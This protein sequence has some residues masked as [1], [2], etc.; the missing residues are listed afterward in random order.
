[1]LHFVQKISSITVFCTLWITTL[2]TQDIIR[3]TGNTLSNVDYHHGQ[4]S[5]VKGVHNI[6]VLRAN[7]EHPEEAEGYGW[8]YSHA[9]M[10]AYRNNTF[11]LQYLSNSVGEHI[12]PGQ[13]LLVTSKDGCRWSKP[14]ALFPRYKIPDGTIKEGYPGV[15]RDLY[16]VMHQRM[17][18]YM[19]EKNRLLAL[20]FYGICMDRKDK[21]NDGK[22]IGRVV[23]EIYPDG[24]FGPVYFIRYNSG[25]G[26]NNTNYSF[27]DTSKDKGFVEAC[28]E[29]LANPLMMQQWN[30]EADRDDPLIPLKKQFKALSYYHLPDGRVVGLWKHALTAISNDEGKTWPRPVRAP[31][32]VNR[33]AKIWGQRTSDG[34]YATVYNP[35]EFR[36]PLAVSVSENGLDYNNLLLVQGEISPMRY[37]GNYKNYGPQYVRG[38]LEGNG[39]PPDG[40][41]WVTYSMNKEDIWVASIPVPVEDYEGEPVNDI[42]SELPEGAELKKWNIYSPIWAPVQIER[43]RDGTRCLSL[44]DRDRYDYAKAERLF[45]VSK[46]LIAEFSVIPA[47]KDK[48]A[49]HIEFQDAKGTAAVRLIFDSDS[50]FKTKYS[51]RYSSMMNYEAGKQYN[52]RVEL[53]VKNRSYNLKV[54]GK[55]EATDRIFFAPVASLERIVFRTGEIRRFPNS[56]TPAQQDFDLPRA[57]EPVEEAAFYIKSVKI[58]DSSADKSLF[59]L[60][61]EN[62]KHHVD[63]FNRM[64]D[65]NIIQAVSNDRSWEWMSRNIPF[66]ECPQ[67]NFEEIYY[68]RWW[69]LRKHIKETPQGYAITEFLVDRSYADKYN[70]ISCALGHHIYEAR[71]LHDSKYLEDYIH[72]WYRGREGKNM[73]KLRNFSSWSAD[74]LY[75]RFLVDGDS[76]F[77]ID[78]LPD[79]LNDYMTWESMRRLPEGLFWQYDVRDGMEE[80]ISGGRHEK[81]ARPTVNSYMYGNAVAISKLSHMA[82]RDKLAKK[83]A[84]KADTLKLLILNK[85]WNPESNFFEALKPDGRLADAREAI[86]FIPWYFNLPDQGYE[87]AWKQVTDKEGFLAPFG[88]T[89]AERRHPGFRTHGCC[90]C[91]WDGAVWPFATSQTMTAMANLMNNYKQSVITDSIYF[92]LMELYVESQYYRGRPYI[93]EYLDETTGYWLKGDQERSRYYNH[94]TFCDLIISGLVGFRPHAGNIIEVNPLIPEEKWDWFCLDNILYHGKIVTVFW[95]RNGNRYNRGKGL[96]VL[97]DGK[98]VA[99]SGKLERIISKYE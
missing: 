67:D 96:H 22:G 5:P 30:E 87:Q 56:D 1:M 31:G 38:I 33:N 88:L 26:K 84:A 42:F 69:T 64:E 91:E 52:I 49:L 14:I 41:L 77:L 9:P 74:A 98:E 53:D 57:G 89:T 4:L 70:L 10:L 80:S 92:R 28:D 58:S 95:D 17:G 29:L 27:Y 8:T 93:G 23:R 18:F 76:S 61:P 71:W 65:E 21:P 34:R 13:T 19:S 54:N 73:E 24:S 3:Y 68:F 59:I 55:S 50:T 60:K 85:L 51:Y 36:W 79:L 90:K 6:Q 81:N 62:Y 20:A 86:G 63:F 66:F 46:N 43:I 37:G 47:Q 78:M 39:T 48:G 40:N 83:Y 16:A 15:A 25:W 2:Q 72:L 7:R 75:N 35:S 97:V 12:P 11:Y 44:K 94:S 45:P 32:F 99:S 82:G